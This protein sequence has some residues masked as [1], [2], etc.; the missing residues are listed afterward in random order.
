[1]TVSQFWF[2]LEVFDCSVNYQNIALGLKQKEELGYDPTIPEFHELTRCIALSTTAKFD[3]KPDSELIKKRIA[4]L[5]RKS[6]S[7]VTKSDIDKY[8]EEA[9]QLLYEEETKKPLQKKKTLGDAS[10]SGLIKFVQGV[11]DIEDVRK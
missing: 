8:I 2:N 9:T 5:L 1:M 4:K 6:K 3:F 7:R 10:E 11:L